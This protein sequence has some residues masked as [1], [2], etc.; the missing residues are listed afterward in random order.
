MLRSSRTR[1]YGHVDCSIGWI[2]QVH[3]LNLVA[4]KRSRAKIPR[5]W[6]KITLETLAPGGQAACG[7]LAPGGQAAQGPRQTDTPVSQGN[8]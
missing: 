4:Q 8:K 7:I 2:S 3:M 1:W 6:A 5:A